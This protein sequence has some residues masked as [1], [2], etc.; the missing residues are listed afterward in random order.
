[1]AM[2]PAHWWILL[3]AEAKL[4]ETGD[5][6]YGQLGG[7]LAALSPAARG[8]L[9]APRGDIFEVLD[10]REHAATAARIA[11]TLKC[12]WLVADLVGAAIHYRVELVFGSERNV[13]PAIRGDAAA[14]PIVRYSVLQ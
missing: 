9:V 10:F 13:P 5:S 2:A 6:A 4:R 11:Q 1:M 8:E 14:K 3:R 12:N 7:L